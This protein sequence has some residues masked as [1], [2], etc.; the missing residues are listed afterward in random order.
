MDK[1]KIDKKGYVTFYAAAEYN[2]KLYIA[3]RDN[4]GLLE[5]DLTTGETIIKNVLL[6]SVY[7]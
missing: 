3:D 2:G 4:R 5:Y 7:I 1:L 6:V